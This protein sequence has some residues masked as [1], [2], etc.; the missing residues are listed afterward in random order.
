MT[1]ARASCQTS[2]ARW[3]GSAAAGRAPPRRAATGPRRSRECWGGSCLACLAA[4]AQVADTGSSR[5]S[6]RWLPARISRS[7]A[8]VEPTWA[9]RPLPTLLQV[10]GEDG[11]SADPG[12]YVCGWLKRGPS[13]EPAAQPA[14]QAGGALERR[15]SSGGLH[16]RCRPTACH[17]CAAQTCHVNHRVPPACRHHRHQPGGCG[18]DRGCDGADA[19][20][21]PGGGGA[22]GGRRGAAPPAAAT[23]GAGGAARP[24][25]V[26]PAAA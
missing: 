21:L 8:C 20:Q 4:V 10:C 9:W 14:G 17:A 12:L 18:A 23:R 1:A 22:A 26:R 13:G 7:K 25:A 24:G 15:Q 6:R 19:G 5:G 11:A 2:W 3:A 16:A